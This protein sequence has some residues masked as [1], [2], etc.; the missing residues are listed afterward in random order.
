VYA[1]TIPFAWAIGILLDFLPAVFL[2]FK[3]LF[4]AHFKNVQLEEAKKELP[5]RL[6]KVTGEIDR[7]RR[8]RNL[9][10]SLS[11]GSLKSN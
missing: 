6:E 1:S 5:K 4:Y 10:K 11:A 3:S 2:F 8:V 7:L 9:E